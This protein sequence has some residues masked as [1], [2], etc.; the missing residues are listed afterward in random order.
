MGGQ[1]LSLSVHL[2]ARNVLHIM[3]PPMQKHVILTLRISFQST[4]L[5]GI[6]MLNA[7]FKNPSTQLLN[8]QC[9]ECHRNQA[10]TQDHLL[11][12]LSFDKLFMWPLLSL[13]LTTKFFTVSKP[14]FFFG[15]C[16]PSCLCVSLQKLLKCKR[17]RGDGCDR[18]IDLVCKYKCGGSSISL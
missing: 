3:P 4:E 6:Y 16:G 12:I 8:S 18:S 14:E 5:L 1:F 2:Q 11:C 9:P 7:I 10:L 17:C 13:S 15:R